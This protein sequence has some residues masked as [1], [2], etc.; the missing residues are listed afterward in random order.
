M[1]GCTLFASGEFLLPIATPGGRGTTTLLLPPAAELLGARFFNQGFAQ[2]PG[3]NAAGIVV[4]NP[5][6]ASIGGK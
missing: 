3:A 6:E 4:S 2:D 1:P 5:R